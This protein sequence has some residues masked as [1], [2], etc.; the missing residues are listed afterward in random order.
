MAGQS[1]RNML[2]KR[3]IERSWQVNTS[4]EVSI[5]INS[6]EFEAFI[7]AWEDLGD[8]Y[9]THAD[10]AVIG[11]EVLREYLSFTRILRRIL[12][13]LPRHDP[14]HTQVDVAITSL[15]GQL[16]TII[17]EVVTYLQ[18]QDIQA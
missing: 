16:E 11:V 5:W 4:V 8:Y 3:I 17:K 15:E 2:E 6:T 7:S 10:D 18:S 9:A 13:Q 14:L 1:L 12:L